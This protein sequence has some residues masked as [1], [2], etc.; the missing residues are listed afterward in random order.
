MIQFDEH[1]CQMGWFNHQLRQFN[2]SQ[3]SKH[4]NWGGDL[5]PKSPTQ[6][7]L[8]LSRYDWKARLDE[9]CWFVDLFFF[10]RSSLEKKPHLLEP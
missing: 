3:A 4:R 8:H 2:L 5:D 9:S 6:K 7:I 1:M 10:Q